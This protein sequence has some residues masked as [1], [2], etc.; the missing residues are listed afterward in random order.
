VFEKLD[1]FNAKEFP[2]KTASRLSNYTEEEKEFM[3]PLPTALYE[4]AVWK[5]L[6]P[7]FNYHIHFEK[8]YYSVPC[9]YIKQEVDVRIT[10][11]VVEI[12]A[13]GLRISS[14]RRLYGKPGQYS[15]LPAHMPEKHRKYGDWNAN[16]FIKWAQSIGENTEVAVKAILTGHAV[17]QQGYRACMGVLKL[18]ERNGAGRLEAACQKALTYTPCPTYRHIDSI[19]K[20]GWDNPG[21]APV[22]GS[23]SSDLHAFVRGADY[24]GRVR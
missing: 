11:V 6:T 17:E 1:V 8:N 24:Y 12:F 13:D 5:K 10:D 3:R 7:G 21:K 19:I 2:G 18:A 9:Q 16:R 15:T 20:S 23:E 14:H 22:D 4:L